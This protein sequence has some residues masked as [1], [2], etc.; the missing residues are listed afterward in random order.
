[1]CIHRGSRQIGG[2]CVEVESHGQRLLID[3]G[4][5]LDAENN[6]IQYLPDISGLDG[7]DP[8]LLGIFISHPHLDHF[9]TADTYLPKN[10]HWHGTS[11]SPNPNCR[12]TL[13]TKQL[14]IPTK[15][16]DFK[17]GQSFDVGQNRTLICGDLGFFRL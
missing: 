17:S 11:C 7:N 2:S 14:A 16:W 4:L 6:S 5:P 10:S 15:G 3:L 12:R 13:L 1:M 9:G 8:S